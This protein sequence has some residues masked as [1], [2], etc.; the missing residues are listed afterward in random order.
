VYDGNGSILWNGTLSAEQS[1]WVSSISVA[2]DG[3]EL[4]VTQ[5]VPACCHGS[6]T[7]TSSNKVILFDRRGV[8]SWEYPTYNPPLASIVSGNNQDIF[9][10]T[11][12]GRIICL[13][14]DGT[15]RW[16]THVDAPVI[17]L[18]TSRNGSMI[19]ATG[20][21]NYY[22]NKLYGEPLNPDDIFV[23]DDNGILLW[24]YQTGGMNAAAVSDDGSII[25]VIDRRSGN[26]L[27]FNRSGSKLMER[28]LAGTTSAIAMSGD[29]NLV[30]VE[31][32]EGIVYGLDHNGSPV[33]N[34]SVEPDSYGIAVSGNGNIVVL[35]NGRTITTYNKNGDL[36]EEYPADSRI[37]SIE[38]SP[39][40]QSLI[41]GTEQ[42]LIFFWEKGSEPGTESPVVTP[43]R[44]MQS[45]HIPQTPKGAPL[46]P[47]IPVLAL[48]ICTI[49]I[50]FFRK[51]L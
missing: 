25:A 6:V 41:V 21:S 15:S 30:V 40:T 45:T 28:S 35:G 9:I 8:K 1:P 26:I 13:N 43:P 48:V 10:G 42:K 38:S 7:N 46:I 16:I 32:R 24:K 18:A 27:L 34:V 19:V 5:L 50:V 33:W 51:Y 36:L 12:D 31:T 20:E 29:G 44:T 11:D 39:D 22:F 49:G 14:R 37:Q 23:L 47:V 3:N 2:P 4:T 17:S